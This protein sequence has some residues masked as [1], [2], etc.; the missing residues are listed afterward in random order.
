MSTNCATANN[1]LLV[2]ITRLGDLLQAS[3]TIIGLKQENPNAKITVAVDKQF[4]AICNGIPGVDDTYVMDMSMIC[5]CLEREGEGIVSAYAYITEVL[6]ELRSRNFDYCLNMSSS[7]YTALMLK[8][9]GIKES[10]GWIADDEGYRLIS[11]PWSM[12]FAAFVY[13]SNRDYNSLNLVDILRC[14]AGVTAH[15]DRLMYDIPEEASASAVTFLTENGIAH[16]G[17]LICLQA[18]A[19]QEKRQ[20]EPRKFSALLKL[21]VENLNARVIMT[22]TIQELPIVNQILKGY[23]HQQVVS[24]VGRTNLDQLSAL[25]KKADVLITGDTG[26]MHLAVA[27]GTPVVAL[28]LA[29]ALAFE[30]GPYSEGNFVIQPQLSCCPCNPNFPCSRPDCHDQISPELVFE[31]TKLR[32]NTP[33]GEEKNIHIP[34][35]LANPSEV[36]VYRTAFDADDFLE[37]IPLNKNIAAMRSGSTMRFFDAARNAYRAL[38]KEQFCQIAAKVPS[39]ESPS[40]S[41]A[42]KPLHSEVRHGLEAIQ[43]HAARGRE[44]IEELNKLIIDINSPPSKLGAVNGEINENNREIE[45]LGLTYP[46][47][48]ALV[49]MFIMENQNLRGDDP[50]VLASQ[51]RGLYESLYLRTEKFDKLFSHYLQQ[52]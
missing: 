12:L 45:E 38:W 41:L 5:R 10:R 25:L 50:L 8:M 27:V 37:F 4:A 52:Q 42:A 3:P 47:A 22:G 9:L 7:G 51:L 2:A 13:H 36:M 43:A 32:L 18:G 19:S 23:S 39:I 49:R 33:M 17:P 20:W 24:A 6:E 35:N 14:S 26:P 21:L 46:I 40:K 1:I 48:G 30:T 16:G 44:L 34:I 15:P 11:N 31:V 29:S 28:F